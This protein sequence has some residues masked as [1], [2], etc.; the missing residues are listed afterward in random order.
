MLML[1][2]LWWLPLAVAA[3][4]IIPIWLSTRHLV[5]EA[6]RLRAS[7]VELAEVRTMVAQVRNEIAAVGATRR[8]LP[9]LGPR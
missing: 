9:D 6:A 8:S 1:S 2:P 7:V 3:A 4:A 5:D